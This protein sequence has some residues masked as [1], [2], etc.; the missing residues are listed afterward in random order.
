[1]RNINIPRIRNPS[2]A[3]SHYIL[4]SFSLSFFLGG[5]QILLYPLNTD[6]SIWEEN[7]VYTRNCGIKQHC[8]TQ[9]AVIIREG[10]G[11]FRHNEG[12]DIGTEP[13]WCL[14]FHSING[15]GFAWSKC[16]MWERWGP[17]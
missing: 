6:E 2:N 1:M 17:F 3:H 7:E 16:G 9:N 8:E 12:W 13:K 4:F 14:E 10:I 15:G 11:Q 5:G